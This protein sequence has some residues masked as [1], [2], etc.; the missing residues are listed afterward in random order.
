M[1][2][3]KVS[4]REYQRMRVATLFSCLFPLMEGA[5]VGISMTT[6]SEPFE[7]DLVD[8]LTGEFKKIVDL[9]ADLEPTCGVSRSDN[10]IVYGATFPNTTNLQ[11]CLNIV[12]LSTGKIQQGQRYTSLWFSNIAFDRVTNQTFVISA[13]D[14]STSALQELLPDQTLRTIV[15]PL[16][17]FLQAS[18]YSSSKHMFFLVMKGQDPSVRQ[19]LVLGTVGEQEGKTLFLVPVDL[20]IYALVYDDTHDVLYA[21]GLAGPGVVVLASVDYTTGTILKTFTKSSTLSF[22]KAACI[23]KEGTAI[24]SSMYLRSE[25][26]VIH[27]MD[28][29]SGNS[30]EVPTSRA[31]IMMDFQ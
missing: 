10:T 29:S 31:A 15:D 21:W 17:F 1:K 14:Y 20:L 5:I 3:K 23:N 28:L 27:S 12:D 2:P 22:A 4:L 24:Y 30:T 18:A 9:G 11:G 7:V 25:D 16:P 8:P 13:V 6:H 26:T 19:L